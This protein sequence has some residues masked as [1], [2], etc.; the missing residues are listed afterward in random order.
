MRRLLTCMHCVGLG[1]DELHFGPL[2]QRLL[3]LVRRGQQLG[4]QLGLLLLLVVLLLLL[5]V[6]LL[7]V[8]VLGQL[9]IGIGLLLDLWLVIVERAVRRKMRLGWL[10]RLGLCA[11][12]TVRLQGRAAGCGQRIAVRLGRRIVVLC[13]RQTAC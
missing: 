13:G 4:I 10:L 11:A 5:Q 12:G 9:V 1:I 3:A 8:N 6:G 2:G 7:F